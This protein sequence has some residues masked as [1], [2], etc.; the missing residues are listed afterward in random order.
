MAATTSGCD[1]P[2]SG[3][4]RR[5]PPARVQAICFGDFREDFSAAQP[6][7]RGLQRLHTGFGGGQRWWQRRDLA[8]CNVSGAGRLQATASAGGYYSTSD[9]ADHAGFVLSGPSLLIDA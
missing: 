9:K 2:S 6:T 3:A 5:P 4:G 7:G 1:I 8:G